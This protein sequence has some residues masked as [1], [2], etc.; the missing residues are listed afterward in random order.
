MKD[1]TPNIVVVI[2][3]NANGVKDLLPL[4]L[5]DLYEHIP[6]DAC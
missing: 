2:L 4:S 3:G 5:P 1:K 6:N